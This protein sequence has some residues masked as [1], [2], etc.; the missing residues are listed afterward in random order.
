MN[1]TI[2]IIEQVMRSHLPVNLHDG[3]VLCICDMHLTFDGPI[4]QRRHVATNIIKA[5]EKKG[6]R[7]QEAERDYRSH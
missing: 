7:F 3:D 4:E 1:N 2:D 6:Y 5:I